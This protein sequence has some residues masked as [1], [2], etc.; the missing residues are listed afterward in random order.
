METKG[1]I[2]GV[3]L[4][5]RKSQ[6]I[7]FEILTTSTVNAVFRRTPMSPLFPEGSTIT[8]CI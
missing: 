7:P 2:R 8:L 4:E 3:G 1:R 6:L 5:R